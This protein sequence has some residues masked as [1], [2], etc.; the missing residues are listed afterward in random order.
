[1]ETFKEKQACILD[2]AWRTAQDCEKIIG[3]AT[4]QAPYDRPLIAAAHAMANRVEMLTDG[5]D[6]SRDAREQWI[7]IH[8]RAEICHELIDMLD[9][10]HPDHAEPLQ[11]ASRSMRKLADNARAMIADLA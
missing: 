5:F 8:K 1:M 3:C 9:Q 7:A 2:N 4:S 6:E 10:P 11:I